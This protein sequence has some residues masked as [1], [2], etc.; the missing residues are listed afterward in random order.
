MV[1]QFARWPEA[2]ARSVEIAE[3]VR[4][5]LDDLAYQYP[6]ETSEPGVTAQQTLTRLTWEGVRWR[7]PE[8]I[9]GKVN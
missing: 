9:P 6:D 7:Y 8:G 2:V 3:R 4:F 5:S 1:R